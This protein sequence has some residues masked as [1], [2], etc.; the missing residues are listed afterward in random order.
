MTNL[1]NKQELQKR[2]KDMAIGERFYKCSIAIFWGNDFDFG[3]WKTFK[4][5]LYE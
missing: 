2:Y 1:I 4:Q 3:T 5:F